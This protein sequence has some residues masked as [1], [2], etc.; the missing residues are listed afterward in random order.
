MNIKISLQDLL[1]EFTGSAELIVL[2]VCYLKEL[3]FGV[4]L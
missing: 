2:V 4:K 3:V 1:V